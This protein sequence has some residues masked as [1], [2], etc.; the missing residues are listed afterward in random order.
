MAANNC[1][2]CKKEAADRYVTIK[3]VRIHAECFKCK[4]CDVS[5]GGK[6]YIQHE[7]NFLCQAD[8]YALAGK[9]MRTL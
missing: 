5:L 1:G 3:D 7:G 8:Y 4:T 6:P 9:K 2:V